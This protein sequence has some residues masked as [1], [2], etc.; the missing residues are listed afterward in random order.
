MLDWRLQTHIF[1]RWDKRWRSLGYVLCG[2]LL[3]GGASEAQAMGKDDAV[4]VA[5]LN[6]GQARN[7]RP[8]ALQQ[9]ILYLTKRTSVKVSLQTLRLPPSDPRLFSMPFLLLTGTQ[10]FPPLESASILRLRTYLRAGGLL[11]IDVSERGRQSPFDR[12]ARRFVQRLFPKKSL[13]KISRNHTIYRSF[14]LIRRFA[15]R[16]LRRPYLEGIT[17]DDR[18]VVLYSLN[19]FAGA[20]SKDAFGQWTFP[21]VPGDVVQRENA[22]RIG[23]NVLMYALCVNYKQDLVHA[24]TIMRRRR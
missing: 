12:S 7:N 14:Y 8:R 16:V 22:F 23:I 2:I 3:W 24:P 15:G 4:Q 10:A 6:V 18:S 17:L 19:D 1:C 21:V 9:L 5:Y 20:W 13:E 11:W